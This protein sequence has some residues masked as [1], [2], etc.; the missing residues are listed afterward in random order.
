M[1]RGEAGYICT[2]HKHE[3]TCK[4]QVLWMIAFLIGWTLLA[5]NFLIHLPSGYIE[6]S[7]NDCTTTFSS[8]CSC[9]C[10]LSNTQAEFDRIQM[11]SIP[12]SIEILGSRWLRE[13]ITVQVY[14]HNH[15]TQWCSNT[16]VCMCLNE[17]FLCVHRHIHSC[18]ILC[19]TAFRLILMK[20]HL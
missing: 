18:L 3:S 16:C 17:M 9:L 12:A 5:L 15:S 14:A 8:F 1:V 20:G 11:Y 19:N 2:F 10:V 13:G 7:V 6:V 4:V